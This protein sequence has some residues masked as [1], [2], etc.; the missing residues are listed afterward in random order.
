MHN[1]AHFCK[2]KGSLF[3]DSGEEE[4]IKRQTS[5]PSIVPGPNDWES[6][7]P[8]PWTKVC[9]PILSYMLP[10]I[11]DHSINITLTD[12]LNLALRPGGYAIYECILFSTLLPLTLCTLSFPFS[13]LSMC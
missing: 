2:R 8:L 13:I 4:R 12:Y 9:L 3:G 5:I 11:V 1:N 6:S 7:A 10:V